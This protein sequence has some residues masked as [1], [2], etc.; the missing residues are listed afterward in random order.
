[1]LKSQIIEALATPGW[2]RPRGWA[3]LILLLVVV[4]SIVGCKDWLLWPRKSMERVA[5]TQCFR[6][7]DQPWSLYRKDGKDEF[8]R[9]DKRQ[10]HGQRWSIPKAYYSRKYVAYGPLTETVVIEVGRPGLTPGITELTPGAFLSS[11][12]R[13]P[14][15]IEVNIEPLFFGKFED[16]VRLMMDNNRLFGMVKT[17][18]AFY[19]MDVY[20][21]KN[22]SKNNYREIY[23]FPPAYAQWFVSCTIKP[24]LTL[25]EDLK[26]VG[27]CKIVS[28]VD[29]RV[30]IEYQIDNSELP[31][32]PAINT[33]M[34][35]LIRSF[36]VNE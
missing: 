11:E 31:Q 9:D 1:M 23:L 16:E 10:C 25:E 4:L 12:Q 29:D 20:D 21:Q 5:F 33:Q 3:G 17:Q 8:Y 2:R 28:N 6:A 27:G 14:L 15:Y 26:T 32:L 24:G 36:M 7:F 35:N 22:F 19:D 18:S 13:I 34:T 30:Y